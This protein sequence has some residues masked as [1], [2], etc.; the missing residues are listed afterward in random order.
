[1]VLSAPLV[2]STWNPFCSDLNLHWPGQSTQKR[3]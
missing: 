2:N 3:K 1:M